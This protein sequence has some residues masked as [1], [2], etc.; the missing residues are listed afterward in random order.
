VLKRQIVA[1]SFFLY[2][3]TN[4]ACELTVIKFDTGGIFIDLDLSERKLSLRKTLRNELSI[5]FL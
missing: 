4:D 1:D 3:I 5:L 2:I